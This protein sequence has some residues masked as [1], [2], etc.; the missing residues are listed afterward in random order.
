MSSSSFILS[1][2]PTNHATILLLCI[3]WCRYIVRV[4]FSYSS[5]RPPFHQLRLLSENYWW[6]SFFPSIKWGKSEELASFFKGEI[7]KYFHLEILCCP[8]VIMDCLIIFFYCILWKFLYFLWRY[9]ILY[10]NFFI[11]FEVPCEMVLVIL[12]DFFLLIFLESMNLLVFLGRVFFTEGFF[13]FELIS[14]W[15][16]F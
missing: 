15:T 10:H 11:G 3:A 13:F 4:C 8:L 6:K 1:F 16:N 12:I 5:A 14:M 9:F 2:I 7:S